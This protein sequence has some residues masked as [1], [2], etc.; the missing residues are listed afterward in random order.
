MTG[1]LQP[2]RTG[3]AWQ[4]TALAAGACAALLLHA[5]ARGRWGVLTVPAAC[6]AGTAA[7]LAIAGGIRERELRRRTE[8]APVRAVV[9]GVVSL[10]VA[11]T[12]AATLVAFLR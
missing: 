9:I 8:P 5:A 7:L 12:A 2:E 6:A 3:L 10:A 4:R 1:G 11:G